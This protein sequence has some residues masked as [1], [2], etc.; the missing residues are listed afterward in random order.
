M[1]ARTSRRIGSL[2][3]GIAAVLAASVATAGAQA[4]DPI[5]Y[6][7]D[8]P[9]Q[10]TAPGN[11]V[12]MTFTISDFPP[13]ADD[14][15]TTLDSLD[16]TLSDLSGMSTIHG[17]SDSEPPGTVSSNLSPDSTALTLLFDSAVLC[18][19][20]SGAPPPTTKSV[21]V[22]VTLDVPA[23]VPLG[24]L[25]SLEG[26]ARGFATPPNQDYT[27]ERTGFVLVAEPPPP[28]PP[29]TPP[30]APGDGGTGPGGGTSG[31]GTSGGGGTGAA[32]PGS[33]MAATAVR[34]TA[35]FTG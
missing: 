18:E 9:I 7:V 11:Q 22:V 19:N 5:L 16:F 2:I 24:T 15:L 12:E 26:V 17:F 6:D 30:P 21:T 20:P 29:P 33:A 4:G 34:A 31:G 14:N 10:L 23:E 32:G 25:L 8:P 1:K 35:R 27:A 28:P 13:C 3:A